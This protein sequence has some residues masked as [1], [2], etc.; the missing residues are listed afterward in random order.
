MLRHYPS[1]SNTMR[2]EVEGFRRR[3]GLA[4]DK[5]LR[6]LVVATSILSVAALAWLAWLSPPAQW[7]EGEEGAS[8]GRSH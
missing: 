5:W 1:P 6:I 7:L 3:K 2:W 4:V 8:R